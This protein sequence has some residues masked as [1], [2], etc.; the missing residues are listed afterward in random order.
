MHS[1]TT[2][3]SYFATSS[4]HKMMPS[5]AL[6]GACV[7]GEIW[8]GRRKEEEIAARE[9]TPCCKGD[10]LLFMATRFC[11]FTIAM[12][13]VTGFREALSH[14][15]VKRI[16]ISNKAVQAALQTFF[17]IC[18]QPSLWLVVCL[19]QY[20]HNSFTVTS[21][22]EQPEACCPENILLW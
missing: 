6:Q 4:D 5:K 20:W 15:Q 7:W 18:Y 1:N 10:A 9:E 16:N 19:K 11:M 21:N 17:V 2:W 22:L 13:I 12:P 14:G 8:G 3:V